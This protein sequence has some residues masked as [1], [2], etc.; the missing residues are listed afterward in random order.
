M[1]GIIAW[2]C[3]SKP[4][5]DK[6]LGST[7]AIEALT[8]IVKSI[9]LGITGVGVTVGLVV[10]DKSAAVKPDWLTEDLALKFDGLTEDLALKLDVVFVI[11][12]YFTFN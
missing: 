7:N 4:S 1:F 6:V 12:I 2:S 9:F 8:G 5:L 3:N 11:S 10:N